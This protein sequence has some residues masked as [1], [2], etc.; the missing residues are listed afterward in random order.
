LL[1]KHKKLEK[2][3][4]NFSF[5]NFYKSYTLGKDEE[6]KVIH[7]QAMKA[8][9]E[10]GGKL[11][12]FLPFALDGGEKSVSRLSCFTPVKEPPVSIE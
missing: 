3:F 4:N 8:Y 12:P 6:G 1:N 10:S 11:H 2:V 7:V 5:L 9:R